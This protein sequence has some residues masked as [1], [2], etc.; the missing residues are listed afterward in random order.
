MN[1][2]MSTLMVITTMITIMT[3]TMVMTSKKSITETQKSSP[4]ECGFNP[5][6]SKRMPFSIHFFLIAIIF[7]IFDVEMVI[8]MPMITTMKFSMIKFWGITCIM[9]ITILILGL[10]YEWYNG[11]LNWTK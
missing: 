11:M 2:T 10:Y 5:I 7:L 4:F 9:L 8:I 6:S 3:L 1:L